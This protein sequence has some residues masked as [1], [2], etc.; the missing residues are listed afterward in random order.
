[1]NKLRMPVTIG[2]LLAGVC[3]AISMASAT[4]A[5]VVASD[6]L[7]GGAL[8]TFGSATG[9]AFTPTDNLLVTALGIYDHGA[10]GLADR[11]EVGIFTSTGTELV[12]TFVGAGT[13]AA[14]TP[15]TVDGT[16]FVDVA[17]TMLTGGTA[18][19]IVATNFSSDTF[20]YGNSAVAFATG[21]TWDGFVDCGANDIRSACAI[22]FVGAA[23]NLGPN[24]AFEVNAAPEPATLALLGVA[25]AGIGFS[26][27]RKL[28]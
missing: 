10:D 15:G 12:S 16:R 17:A 25:L 28:H 22:P 19:Y 11:H 9:W 26:R 18:Y 24:F 4:A 13:S 20:A 3:C 21:I 27:R 2:K 23:G 1:M 5:P 8:G 6:Y 14:L 7:G